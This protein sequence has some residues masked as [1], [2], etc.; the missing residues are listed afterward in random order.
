MSERKIWPDDYMSDDQKTSGYGIGCPKC[1]CKHSLA[2]HT[3]DATKGTKY[4]RRVCRNCGR[5]YS[6]YEKIG[7]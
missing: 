7:M 3:R 5:V 6:T 4:R 1:G 2:T